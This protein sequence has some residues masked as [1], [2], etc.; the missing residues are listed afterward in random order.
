I[1]GSLLHDHGAY[2]ARGLNIAYGSGVT[3][4]LPYNVGAYSLD[5]AVVLTNK[6][7]T[8]PIRGAGQPQ[9]AFVMERLLHKAGRKIGMDRAEI[10]RRNLVR[11]EQMPVTKPL[12]LRGG[13]NVILDSGDYLAT[14]KSALERAGWSAFAE[15]RRAARARG[16][17][18][19]IGLANYVEGTGRGPYE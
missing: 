8:A 1:R 4:P 10:R 3:L 17:C 18:R 6:G 13:T 9:A 16:L 11:A 19:G 14:M 12:K 15:R 7:P 5:V 2:T